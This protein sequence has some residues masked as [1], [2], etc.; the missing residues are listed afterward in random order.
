MAKAKPKGTTS[1]TL[2]FGHPTP[3][4]R[5]VTIG[6]ENVQL[7]FTPGEHYE[8]TDEEIAGLELEISGG[9]LVLTDLNSA[10]VQRPPRGQSADATATIEKLEAKIEDLAT[11]NAQL[12]ADLEKL[13]APE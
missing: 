1:Y 13:T 8:L 11:E 2:K 3:F 10:G 12:R 7:V 9:L 5:T 6:D 4:R